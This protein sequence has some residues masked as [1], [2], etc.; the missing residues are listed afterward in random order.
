[1]FSRCE[2]T[3]LQGDWVRVRVGVRVGDGLRIQ[4]S[5]RVRMRVG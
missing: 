2:P 3:W 1:M 5:A 4:V